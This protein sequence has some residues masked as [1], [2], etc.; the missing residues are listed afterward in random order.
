MA[1]F[2]T[3]ALASPLNDGLYERLPRN[4]LYELDSHWSPQLPPG[5]H[6]FSAVGIS[7][8]LVFITQRGN[9]SLPPVLVINASTGA[10]VRPKTR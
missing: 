4:D 10:L 9:A 1:A 8:P 3:L 5:A 7:Y 2:L 6:T